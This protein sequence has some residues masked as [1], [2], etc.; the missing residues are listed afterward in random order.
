MEMKLEAA[1]GMTASGSVAGRNFNF[2]PSG[3]VYSA[4]QG[5]HAM[6]APGF[7][8][9]TIQGTLADGTPFGFSQSVYIKEGSWLHDIPLTVPPETVDPAVTKPEDDLWKSL[10]VESTPEK[11][12]NGIFTFPSTLLPVEYCLETYDCFPSQFGSRRSYNGSGYI[13]YHTGL[14]I[15]GQVGY[16]ILAAADGIVVYTGTLTVRGGATV[17]DHGWGVYTTYMH[18]SEILVKPGD[19]VTAGQLIGKIGNTGRVQG[20]HLHWEVLVGGVPTNPIQWL[21]REYP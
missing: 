21:E 1:D 13:F 4:L 8:P 11:M 2:Y 7:Y 6:Q 19:H 9:L 5:I 3:G 15:G 14:D 17:I 20:P 18:Q 10:F 12:W 16:D